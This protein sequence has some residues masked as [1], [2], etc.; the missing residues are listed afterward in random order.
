MTMNELPSTFCW[1]KMGTEAGEELAVIIRR[2]EWERQL[3]D[4]CFF[5]GIGQSL[6]ENARVATRDEESLQAIFSPMPSKAKAIDVEPDEVVLW[7]AWID[8][9]G[10]TRQLP[11]HCFVTSRAFLPSGRKKER[12]Y[13]LVCFSSQELNTLCDEISIFPSHLRNLSTNKPLGASQVTA[14]VRTSKW[15]DDICEAKSYSVILMAEL[16]PPYCVQLAEPIVL[17]KYEVAEVSAISASGDIE[18]WS[19]LVRRLR[20]RMVRQAEWLQHSLDLPEMQQL[21]SEM[22]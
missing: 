20:S 11:T 12:H 9:Q 15:T 2:K 19:S 1:T 3:G 6:G 14:V 17:S 5:W 16:R 21:S 7:N 22:S 18:S 4:G 13:A 8:K 10:R